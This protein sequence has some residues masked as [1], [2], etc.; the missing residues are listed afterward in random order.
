MYARLTKTSKNGGPGDPNAVCLKYLRDIGNEILT[1][2]CTENFVTPAMLR[3]SSLESS[4]IQ[5]YER[6][7]KVKVEHG[8]FYLHDRIRFGASPDGRI[9]EYGLLEAKCFLPDNHFAIV[10]A[11][12][13]PKENIHQVIGGL[14]CA[15]ERQWYDWIAYC[16]IAEDELQYFKCHIDRTP[17]INEGIRDAEAMVEDFNCRVDARV[18]MLR[19]KGREMV[20]RSQ[21]EQGSEHETLCGLSGGESDG[22]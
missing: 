12:T 3:G 19:A 20:N 6:F 21:I 2:L 14:S 5:A 11:G 8:G 7:E 17:I 1:G 18:Q 10:E 4:A 22:E 15:P 13:L 16:P 9:G